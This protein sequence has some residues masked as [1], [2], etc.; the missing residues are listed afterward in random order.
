[1]NPFYTVRKNIFCLVVR[2]GVYFI[3]VLY[4]TLVLSSA[5]N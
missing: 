3:P 5:K 2:E 1:M 4:L